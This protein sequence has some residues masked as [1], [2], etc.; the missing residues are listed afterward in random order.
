VLDTFRTATETLSGVALTQTEHEGLRS[1]HAT[2][3]DRSA[4][5]E[6]LGITQEEHIILIREAFWP[7]DYFDLT[8]QK[9]HTGDEYQKKIG[10]R[11]VHEY[12]GYRTEAKMLSTDEESEL[13]LTFV[14]KQFLPRTG[15][16]YIDLVELLKTR[17]I[18][19]C[20]PQGRALAILESVRFSYRF[21]Q[22][23]VDTSSIDPTVRF[24]KLIE[25]LNIAQPLV[26]H[27][28]ALLHPDPCH[29]QNPE[30]CLSHTDFHNWVY[31]YFERIGKLIVLE[32]GE[33]PQLP[34]E[35][36]VL[37]GDGRLVGTLHKDGTIVDDFGVIIGSVTVTGH[38]VGMDGKPLAETFGPGLEIDGAAGRNAYVDTQGRLKWIE[39]ETLISWVAR[40]TCD[41]DKVRL[42]HLDGSAL[43]G[44][45]YDRMQRFIRLWH[46]LDWTIAETDLALT[47]TFGSSV[48]GSMPVSATILPGA[49]APVGFDIFKSDCSDVGYSDE[50]PCSETPED[51]DDGDCPDVVKVTENISPDFLHQLV[52]IRKLGDLTGLPLDKLLSFWADISTAGEKSLYSRLF[53]T[54]NLLAID[55][56]FKSDANGNYL[57]QAG[58]ISEHLPVLMAALK[59]KADDLASIMEFRHLP[60]TLTLASAST[61]YRHALLAKILQVRVTDLA[62]IIGLFGDAFKNAQDTL[63]FLGDWGSMEDAGFTF[64]QLNYLIRDHDDPKRPLAPADKTIL[65]ISKTLYD[66][67]NAVDHDHP[68]VP[69][70]KKNEA[71]ADLIRVKA[72]LLYEASV[73]EQIISVLE[74]TSVYTT[75]APPN[76]VI[77]ILDTDSLAKRL[78]YSEQ[79]D[80]TPPSASIQVTGILTDAEKVRARALASDSGWA[81]AVDRVGKQARQFFNDKLLGIFPNSA[82]AITTLLAGDI[83]VPPDP[84]NPAA[85]AANTAL[86]KR[87]YFL[88]FFLPF[89]RQRLAHRL[90]V[91]NLSGATGL[92]TDITDTLLTDVLLVGASGQHA[93]AALEQI[94]QKPVASDNNWKGYLIPSVDDAYTFVARSLAGDSQPP[95]LLIDGQSIPFMVQQEDPSNV[96]STDPASPLKLK[97]GKPYLLEVDG[98]PATGLQWKTT[99]SPTAPIPTS[100]L[101]PD[102]SSSG[103]AEVFIKL[104]KVALIVNAFNLTVD[105]VSY[106][107][108]HAGDFDG[109][110]LNGVTLPHFRRLQ[111]YTG[112]R[113]ML[114]KTESSLLDLF[115]WAGKPDDATKLSERIAAV[116]LWKKDDIRKLIAPE[117]FDL[118][119]PEAFN[120]EINLI[121]LQKAL[122]LSEAVGTDSDRLFAWANPVSRFSVCHKIANDIRATLRSRYDQQDWEQVVKPLHDQLR[123]DQKQALISYL[124]VQPDLILWGVADADSLFEFFLIDVQ[125]DACMETSRIKQA[126]SSVQLFIQRCLLGLEARYGVS[127]EVLDRDRWDWMQKYRVWEANRKVFLY[128][129][130]WIKSE[131]RDDKSPFY[132]ELESELL[133]KDINTQTVED[134]LKNYLFK[135]DEVANLKVVGLFLDEEGKR[136][137][138]FSRTRNAPYFFYYR[139]FQLTKRTGT[140]GRRFR[141]IFRATK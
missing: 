95:A 93:I 44:G 133:Q 55:R 113:N 23:L 131:L 128:P 59:L 40:D 58:K 120:N 117:R 56:V 21:L 138:V 78:K 123:E 26:P 69:T 19:P 125:M 103:T 38:L 72:G 88:Q 20:F 9:I 60:D 14:K 22:T 98:Q 99:A 111:A 51:H 68:D 91:G 28:E 39:D 135:V 29:K 118:N 48:G 49:S 7:K 27:L 73:V 33:G 108:G 2:V 54:H 35:G 74:G 119:R 105:E 130:N 87:Y 5:A 115:K 41:L 96:W 116:T 132:K 82:E 71:T 25:F 50:G 136:L 43:T 53:L 6:F 85:T 134:A 4:D 79:K 104:S 75:N 3:L 64:R 61:L 124:L 16:Q 109:F 81:K 77:A 15:I 42:V 45:E 10:V 36:G 100:A 70:E 62:E 32:S 139:Y 89:L 106:W 94:H 67:L 97:N 46:K 76:Q 140:P 66:G 122:Q 63:A 129:E 8:L 1:L 83:N 52:A 137:H 18:N 102:Y 86:I 141:S 47:G 65:Q 24:V 121:K 107:Q 11:P 84:D 92:T 17:F 110:D 114:P 57:T 31:C 80:A 37:S 13:G 126:T 12:Y 30:H 101:L 90:T 112:L 127:S 34:I